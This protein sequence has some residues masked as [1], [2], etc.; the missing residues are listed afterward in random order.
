M[1][2]EGGER[3]RE[4]RRRIDSIPYHPHKR[5][6][7]HEC[8]SQS[9]HQLFCFNKHQANPIS[10]PASK[11]FRQPAGEGHTT[12]QPRHA[13]DTRR[14]GRSQEQ[15]G[16]SRHTARHGTAPPIICIM[17]A[18]RQARQGKEASKHRCTR[19]LHQKRKR[20][21]GPPIPDTLDT[22]THGLNHSGRGSEGVASVSEQAHRQTRKT[23]GQERMQTGRPPARHP[24]P[25]IYL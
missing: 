16:H 13:I 19:L 5:E 11:Q 8:V 15:G 9:I 1:K 12:P 24:T 22:L 25:S 21:A 3:A 23:D 6:H 20:Q 7:D 4:R 2:R 14:R 10:Q 18:T 17:P